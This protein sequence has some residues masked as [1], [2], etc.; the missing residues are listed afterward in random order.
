MYEEVESEEN[1]MSP[2]V[3]VPPKKHECEP[4]RDWETVDFPN[5][6]DEWY[7]RGTIWECEKCDRRWELEYLVRSEQTLTLFGRWREDIYYKINWKRARY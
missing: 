2:I 5:G 3:Y 7:P 4:P 6:E 1:D